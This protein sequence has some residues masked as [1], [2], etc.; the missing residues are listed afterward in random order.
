[1]SS[2]ITHLRLYY[3]SLN[4]TDKIIFKQ[5]I[6]KRIDISQ[7]T[8]YRFLDNIP[9]LLAKEVIADISAM[10]VDKLYKPVNL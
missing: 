4:T 5:K 9:N 3:L 6:I 1:M 2:A 8:F 7:S 10:P